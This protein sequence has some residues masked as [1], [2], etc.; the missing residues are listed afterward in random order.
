M[1]ATVRVYADSPD[2]ADALAARADDVKEL[3]KGIEGFQAYYLVKTDGGAVS[4]SVYDNES[5]ASESNSTAAAWL[6]E[7]MPD[8]PG[9][10]PQISAGE[11]VVT[12]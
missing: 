8:L 10:T 6:R 9:A 2:L 5:G 1:Y 3:L 11:V 12:A 7:N 4:V